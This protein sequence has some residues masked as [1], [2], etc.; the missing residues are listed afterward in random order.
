MFTFV[1]SKVSSAGAGSVQRWCEFK[2]VLK[3]LALKMAFF[4]FLFCFK[5]GHNTAEN[6][7]LGSL[8]D[9]NACKQEG[10]SLQLLHHPP[11]AEPWKE[12][13]TL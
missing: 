9:S 8:H 4:P 10:C 13:W 5:Q 3:G 12:K 1:M 11:W 7:P 2:H 6:P